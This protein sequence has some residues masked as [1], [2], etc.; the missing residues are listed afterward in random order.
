MNKLFIIGLLATASA[1]SAQTPASASTSVVF[2]AEP[3]VVIAFPG[4]FYRAVGGALALG[5]TIN[6]VH[7]IEADAILFKANEKGYTDDFKFMPVLATYKYSF[8]LDHKLSLTAGA[9]V[10]ATFE[11]MEYYYGSFPGIPNSGGQYRISNTAFTSGVLGGI[12]YAFSNRVSFTANAHVL[13]LEK[14]NLTTAGNM[15]LVTL[16]V[17]FRF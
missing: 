16:G 12:S 9:S 7:S 10:G 4:D 6:N 5:A 3:S 14:T 17:K 1:V 8:V 15:V 11:K 2:Y 13:R